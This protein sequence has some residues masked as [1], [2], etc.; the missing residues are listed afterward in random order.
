M[1]SATVYLLIW[2][3]ETSYIYNV[4]LR[5][6]DMVTATILS[7][8]SCSTFRAIGEVS[9]VSRVLVELCLVVVLVLAFTIGVPGLSTLEAHLE[10]T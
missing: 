6:C 1:Y 5:A 2:S 9:V 10:S 7:F 4:N 3:L 8:C